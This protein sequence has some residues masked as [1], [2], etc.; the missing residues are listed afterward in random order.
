MWDWD[1]NTDEQTSQKPHTRGER[2]EHLSTALADVTRPSP[3]APVVSST[4]GP[5]LARLGLKASSS[6][7][8]TWSAVSAG[9]SRQQGTPE[10][11]L[12]ALRPG[13][14]SEA[15][16]LSESVCY[17]AVLKSRKI[18]FAPLLLAVKGFPRAGWECREWTVAR[19]ARCSQTRCS[20][21]L[22]PCA[23][24]CLPRVRAASFFDV[25]SDPEG[26]EGS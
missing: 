1:R 2:K 14:G 7:P 8:E 3:A 25:W 15:S 17:S 20:S 19:W 4:P 5:T 10:W 22:S 6:A 26:M 12:P 13:S 11:A 23:P 9:F 16:Y 21:F 18:V 24:L